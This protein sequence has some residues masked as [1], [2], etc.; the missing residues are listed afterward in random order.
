MSDLDKLT[1][2]GTRQEFEETIKR[3][4]QQA[5]EQDTPL[6]LAFLDIDNFKRHNDSLGHKAGDIIIRAVANT[7]KNLTADRGI[8]YRYGGE[9]YIVLLPSTERE[10]AFLLVEQIRAEIAR[11]QTLSA[12]D[13]TV[14]TGVTISGGIAAFPIDAQDEGE[15]L[16]KADQALYKA[17][18][19][20]RNKILLS[21][22]E[23]MVPK[24]SYYTQTQ[25]SR[26]S[27]LAK[28]MAIGEAVLLRE[29]LD[30]LLIKYLHA[31]AD[32]RTR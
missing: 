32:N 7:I 21:Y 27:T 4:I 13:E 3:A 22:E 30:D 17:K 2:L 6:S 24:T 31:F 5:R 23:K 19:T 12:G 14:P 1:G 29:A 15:L 28:D 11:Q 9:E 25:L 18:S 10:Q 26:L 8:V 16:R 20:G